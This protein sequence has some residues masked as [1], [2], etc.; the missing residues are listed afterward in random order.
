MVIKMFYPQQLQSPNKH[1]V[2]E[3]LSN[4]LDDQSATG[5]LLYDFSF[6]YNS[7]RRTFKRGEI[8]GIPAYYLT[9]NRI[10]T[11]PIIITFIKC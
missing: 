9:F 11:K 3:I 4:Y 5:K 6:E 10:F 7:V 1:H 8:F 2:Q